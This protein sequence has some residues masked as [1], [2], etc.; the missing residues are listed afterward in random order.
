MKK[1]IFSL[2]LAILMILSTAVA[3]S[4]AEP[5]EKEESIELGAT[6]RVA[7][8]GQAFGSSAT[9]T[10]SNYADASFDFEC[11]IEMSKV[12]RLAEEL[13]KTEYYNIYDIDGDVA[14]KLKE[15]KTTGTFTISIDYSDM[16]EVPAAYT[17]DTKSMEGFTDGAKAYYKEIKRELID[18]GNGTKTLKIELATKDGGISVDDLAAGKA[19]QD[20]TFTIEGVKATRFDTATVTG[21]LT[22]NTETNRKAAD[23]TSTSSLVATYTSKKA[24]ASCTVRRPS[25]GGSGVP[26]VEEKEYTL[27]FNVDGNTAKIPAITAKTGTVLN[28][29]E[30]KSVYKEGYV[31]KGWFLDK[32]AA[33][34]VGDTVT[35]NKNIT[36]YAGFVKSAPSI[37][38]LE[39]TDHFAYVSG[40]PD[41]T[42]RPEANIT[43]E[44][45]AMMFYRLLVKSYRE[46]VES[47]THAFTD[48]APERWSDN[49][50]ATLTKAGILN[51][52]PDGT[53]RPGDK[54][55]RAEFATLV[56]NF[57]GVDSTAT[58]NFTDLAGHWAEPYVATAVSKGW[59]A[60]YEDGTFKPNGYITR[61]EAM[62]LVNRILYRYVNDEGQHADAI[63]WPD[64]APGVWYYHAVQE[65][66]N[67][68]DYGRQD[69]GVYEN[70][71]DLRK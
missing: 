52:D 34:P 63:V 54:I 36:V 53:F 58:H 56:V 13:S 57:I 10:V 19:L 18:N 40:Y 44:E 14:A 37:D 68:H 60:G 30:F 70:W 46:T 5:I 43:R 39:S 1:R 38:K 35:L 11:K 45:A 9:A 15:M 3:V 26:V 31:F 50:I 8:S 49:A 65:A 22:G 21:S 67:G 33:T 51:G 20:F 55:T 59:I 41:G 4:A 47:T 61:A 7:R 27:T 29:S 62:T 6:L 64:N 17:A 28:S 12:L 16:L 2:L 23:S 25:S 24:T 48:V 42:V 71:T 69:G 66:T 32:N